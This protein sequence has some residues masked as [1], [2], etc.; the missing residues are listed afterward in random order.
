[1]NHSGH[2]KT[3]DLSK[4]DIN[5]EYLLILAKDLS[6]QKIV[7]EELNLSKLSAIDDSLVEQLGKLLFLSKEDG[8]TSSV[9]TLTLDD[10][11]ISSDGLES[12]LNQTIENTVLHKLS[13]RNCDI[14]FENEN[15]FKW[16]SLTKA[17]AQ[18]CGLRDID[19]AGNEIPQDLRKQIGEELEKNAEIID[20]IFKE[21]DMHQIY[22][23]RKK[24]KP[25]KKLSQLLGNN[26]FNITSYNS[27]QNRRGPQHQKSR[28]NIFA[29]QKF[30]GKALQTLQEKK[31]PKKR[32]V[33]FIDDISNGGDL[34]D[35][36]G[37]TIV[38]ENS[39]RSAMPGILKQGTLD[40]QRG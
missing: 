19:F 5:H 7:I 16:R 17:L 8:I 34:S 27:A 10:N 11:V 28:K 12:L 31:K 14:A 22:K 20:K 18:N 33:G 6:V 25:E 29:S 37:I 40:T 2:I 9:T 21:M 39:Q 15:P 4:S 24:Y 38:R 26:R 1:M 3:L 32:I 23:L 35:R 36:G 30:S 13:L